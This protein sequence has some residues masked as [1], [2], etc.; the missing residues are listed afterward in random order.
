MP[1]SDRRSAANRILGMTWTD[2]PDVSRQG[3]DTQAIRA[4]RRPGARSAHARTLLFHR[5]RVQR[6]WDPI[7][8]ERNAHKRR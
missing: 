3:T 5:R 6:T 1:L 4:L 8:A 7:P 2:R